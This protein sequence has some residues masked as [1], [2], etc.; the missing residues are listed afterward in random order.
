M[1]KENFGK[2]CQF[3][4]DYNRVI[5]VS[6]TGMYHSQVVYCHLQED[7]WVLGF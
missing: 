1:E 5:S 2:C 4:E 6:L 7:L 3:S